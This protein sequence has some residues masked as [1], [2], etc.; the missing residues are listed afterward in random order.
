MSTNNLGTEVFS[1]SK[2]VVTGLSINY[3]RPYRW[4]GFIMF[5]CFIAMRD[6]GVSNVYYKIISM[7]EL[8]KVLIKNR[9][10]YESEMS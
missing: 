7:F 3:V 5:L 1:I 4:G 8:L 2:N 9:V 6:G 10:F